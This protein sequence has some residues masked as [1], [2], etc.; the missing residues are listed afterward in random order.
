VTVFDRCDADAQRVISVAL[1]E[2]RRRGHD[3]LGTEHLLVAL[4]RERRVLP[5]TAQGVLPA[6]PEAAGR[7]LDR[8]IGPPAPRADLLASLGVDLEAV[9][10]AA[11]QAFG[12]EAVERLARGPRP[13]P[14]RGRLRRKRRG[15]MSLLAGG[16]GVAPRVKQVLQRAVE[17]AERQGRPAAAPS[18]VLLGMVDTEA[19]MSNRLLRDMGVDPAQVRR[20]LLDEAA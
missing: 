10:A 20:A 19:A 8:L 12:A 15:C 13:R 18:D 9:R 11:R 5:E 4:L 7:A 1:A 16:L 14:R 2:A 17:H 3:W 6:D